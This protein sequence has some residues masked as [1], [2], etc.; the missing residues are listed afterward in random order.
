MKRV[1]NYNIFRPEACIDWVELVVYPAR[2]T[3]RQTVQD[4]IFEATGKTVNVDTIDRGG[5]VNPYS[6][7]VSDEWVK[8]S[9]AF[10]FRLQDVSRLIDVERA[11]TEIERLLKCKIT[12]TVTGIEVA[13]D[14]IG[15]GAEVAAAMYQGLKNPVS[16]NQRLYRRGKKS[17]D[18]TK[19]AAKQTTAALVA[20]LQAGWM[21][22]IG[23]ETDNL[24]QRIYFKTS[25][26]NG[27]A[28]QIQVEPRARIEIR[29]MGAELPFSTLEQLRQYKFTKLSRHFL[30]RCEASPSNPRGADKE[31]N[32]LAGDAI[33]R[34]SRSWPTVGKSTKPTKKKSADFRHC[35][36]GEQ[37][38]SGNAKNTASPDSE[39]KQRQPDARASG[40]HRSDSLITCETG[41]GCNAYSNE[42]DQQ[43]HERQRV[44]TEQDQ[45]QG[46]DQQEASKAVIDSLDSSPLR[47][48]HQSSLSTDSPLEDSQD[49]ISFADSHLSPEQ[50]AEERIFQQML[51]ED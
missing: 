44:R 20:H 32:E 35:Q 45:D 5:F 3:D 39:R 27:G 38:E 47:G 36:Q 2:R 31:L 1:T 14:I 11:I 6:Q 51:I 22:G 18:Y 4:A 30:F 13:F 41:W 42:P 25:D 26:R 24:Y 17:G 50:E 23:N 15:A 40:A 16:D 37:Q 19:A 46:Q 8:N 10:K 12:T 7:S 9:P 49:E 21:I 28:N 29:L 43:E 33:Q 34:L 48:F